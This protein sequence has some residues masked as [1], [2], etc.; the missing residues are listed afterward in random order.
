MRLYPIYPRVCVLDNQILS[1]QTHITYG[2]GPKGRHELEN[3]V[4]MSE[5]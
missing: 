3:T 2:Y 4:A 1:P 5:N